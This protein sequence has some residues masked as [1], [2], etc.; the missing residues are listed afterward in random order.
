MKGQKAMKKGLILMA[1]ISWV[2]VGCSKSS[3]SKDLLDPKDPVTVTIWHYYNCSQLKA[4]DKLVQEFNMT[5][6]A[7]K[8]IIVEGESQ[9]NVESLEQ[10]VLDSVLNKAG[11]KEMPSVFAAYADT[12]YEIDSLGMV[13]DLSP[14][15]TWEAGQLC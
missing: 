2:C 9:G 8:G 14:Y 10:A 12:A 7:E 1:I 3:D 15:F 11:A 6:G 5:V 4:F 13:V